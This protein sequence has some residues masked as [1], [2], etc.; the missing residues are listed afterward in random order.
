MD[1]VSPAHVLTEWKQPDVVH[2]RLST[3]AG[4]GIAGASNDIGGLVSRPQAIEQPPQIVAL[5]PFEHIV[6]IQP[7]SVIARRVGERRVPCG[8]E[9]VDPRKVEH[10]RINSRAISRVRSVLPVSTTTISSK[11]PY[12]DPRQAGKR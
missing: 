5:V 4:F 10:P 1:A 9:I 6:G 2:N 3:A 8:G 7:E 12:A 11:S